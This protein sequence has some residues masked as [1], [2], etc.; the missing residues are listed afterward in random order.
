[1]EMDDP[2]QP[3]TLRGPNPLAQ[4]SRS[5]AGLFNS[6]FEKSMG[7]PKTKKREKRKRLKKSAQALES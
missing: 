6:Q 3:E 7:K 4:S 5:E 2:D 1:M